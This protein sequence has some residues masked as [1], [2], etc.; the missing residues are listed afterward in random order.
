MISNDNALTLKIVKDQIGDIVNLHVWK[1]TDKDGN[2]EYLSSDNPNAY[3]EGYTNYKEPYSE[4]GEIKNDFIV[5]KADEKTAST[6]IS[7]EYGD[8]DDLKI[9]SDY[10]IDLISSTYQNIS[11][12]DTGITQAEVLKGKYIKFNKINDTSASTDMNESEV[13]FIPENAV[14]DWGDA[15]GEDKFVIKFDKYQELIIYPESYDSKCEY[16]GQLGGGAKIVT[17]TYIGDG[18]QNRKIYLDTTPKAI[19]VNS[20]RG[21]INSFTH[22]VI[23]SG[24]A[25]KDY[26]LGYKDSSTE[27]R[28]PYDALAIV[29]NGFQ[30]D[31]YSHSGSDSSKIDHLTNTVNELYYYIA[32]I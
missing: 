13:Y 16:I 12:W 14:A 26:P 9:S 8:E 19:F 10:E 6:S 4:L 1:K 31:Y 22:T 20:C 30:V 18:T 2:V 28:S 29:E 25:L 17:G 32:F 11:T 15:I 24:L 3:T 7:W 5:I 23:S 27:L 21:I